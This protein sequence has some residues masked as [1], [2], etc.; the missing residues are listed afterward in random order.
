VSVDRATLDVHEF[1][2]D[3]PRAS[4]EGFEITI[5]VILAVLVVV[6]SSQQRSNDFV[7]GVPQ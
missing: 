3:L 1:R 5:I 2:F 7:I 6:F 4:I